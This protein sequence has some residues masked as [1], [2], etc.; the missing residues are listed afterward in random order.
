MSRRRSQRAP[1]PAEPPRS[2]GVAAALATLLAFLVASLLVYRGAFE[3]PF[4]S[5]D[6]PYLTLNP[7][8]QGLSCENL[9]AI[10]DPS[11]PV[12]PLAANYSPVH[13]L[14][15]AV[16]WQ[17]FGPRVRGYHAVNAVLHALVSWLLVLLL[18][19]SRIPTAAAALGGAFFLL[20]PANV[21]AVAWVTQLKTTSAM[22]L[23]LGA[24]LAHPRRPWL[25]A[26]L[27]VL[28]ILAKPLAAFALPVAALL[29]WTREGRV[30]WGW[31]SLWAAA[32][33]GLASVEVRAFR[34]YSLENRPLDPDPLVGGRTVFA[35][36][37]RY[38]AMA[39]TSYGVS[40]F[41]ELPRARSWLDPWWLAGAVSVTL[42]GWRTVR[43]L[44]RRREEAAY[45]V[46]AA[47]S[48]APVSQIFPF[49]YAMGDRYLYMILPGL[50]GGTLL[51][52]AEPWEHLA[53]AGG[54]AGPGES[55]RRAALARAALPLT[56]LVLLGFGLRSAE[57]A[58]LWRS[59]GLLNADSASHYP[60]GRQAHLTRARAAAR[61]G[62]LDGVAAGLRGAVAGGYDFLHLLL[63]EPLFANARSHPGVDAVYQDLARTWIERLEREEHLNQAQLN[64]LAVAHEVRGELEEAVRALERAL[65]VGGRESELVR[66]HLARARADLL[67][68][69]PQPGR[70]PPPVPSEPVGGAP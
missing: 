29:D 52:G 10:L 57:R 26:L 30:R 69:Q 32:F 66:I 12:V 62:D 33:A 4:V 59:A 51:A 20:H 41:H 19:T 63:Q 31:L 34:D 5:D 14:L 60:E 7:H 64:M 68:L 8:V 54:P 28:A 40:T 50:L 47:V 1:A 67:R 45:W 21:E 46:A 16:E 56:L 35:L 22:A 53:G 24:L 13:M 49:E 9:K 18:R 2:A 38:L 39:A 23:A 65:E 58:D 37:M 61:A 25:G 55:P 6:G 36:A 44:G 42:L 3:G 48:F 17:L 70:Q 15:H 11:G 43:A 27:F